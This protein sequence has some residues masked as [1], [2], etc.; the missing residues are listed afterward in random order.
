MRMVDSGEKLSGKRVRDKE[1]GE[2][3]RRNMCS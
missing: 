2:K 3:W 1:I